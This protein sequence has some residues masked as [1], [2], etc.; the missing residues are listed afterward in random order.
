MIQLYK[1]SQAKRELLDRAMLNYS[2]ALQY[3]LEVYREEVIRLAVS[4]IPVSRTLLLSMIDRACL[5]EL[6]RF[7][8]Q[9]FK[10][11]LKIDFAAAAAGFIAQRQRNAN[12]GYPAVFRQSQPNVPHS[13]YFG[14]YALNR[15]YCLLYD[16]YT[17]RF[18]AKLYLMDR[19]NSISG[20]AGL[21]RLSLGYVAHGRPPMPGRAG[22]RRYVV[23]PLAMGAGQYRDLQKALARPDILR[24][25]R[26]IKRKNKFFLLIHMDC[27]AKELLQTTVT[28]GVA[29]NALGE[30]H[31]TVC[32]ETGN[33][34]ASQHL[35]PDRGKPWDSRSQKKELFILA[36]K[37]VNAASDYKARVIV[38][39]I[40]GRNDQAMAEKDPADKLDGA[41]AMKSSHYAQFVGML[42]YKL[43]E[44][45]LP[46]PLAVSANGLYRTCPRCGKQTRKNRLSDQ[47]FA[48][49]ECG[50]ASRLPKSAVSNLAVRLKKYRTDKVPIYT[51]AIGDG[52][53]FFNQTLNFSLL[54]PAENMD[55]EQLYAQLRRMLDSCGF[56]NDRQKYAMLMKL[57][58]AW[59]IRDAVRLVGDA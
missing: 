57:R 24:T 7:H 18:Y 21:G 31:Y 45:A 13:L 42:E 44:K 40:G 35:N 23:M 15:D 51:K 10:D 27:T 59:D 12:A 37:I 46:P 39:A 52:K 19:E 29:R 20:G 17:G 22:K 6:N 5:Q 36:N 28:M 30:L 25:A 47:I 50:F 54:L 14:R 58:S 8:V 53:L 34:L 49:V 26:L 43:P 3:L 4:G 41:G 11:S 16:E 1:P 2:K 55:Y 56:E 9:P 32:D 38:E 33:I 48:C